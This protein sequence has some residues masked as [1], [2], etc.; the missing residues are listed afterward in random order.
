MFK[1]LFEKSVKSKFKTG[2]KI[3]FDGSVYEIKDK[4]NDNMEN[5]DVYEVN[6]K[7]GH[8]MTLEIKVVDK[9]AKKV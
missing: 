7:D 4:Y 6:D 1:E 2:D 8:E 5:M 9:T 3:K